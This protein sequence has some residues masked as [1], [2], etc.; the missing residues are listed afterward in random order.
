M[1]LD[2]WVYAL[3]SSKIKPTGKLTVSQQKKKH[4]VFYWRKHYSLHDWMEQ[5]YRQKGGEEEAFNCIY[6]QLEKKDIDLL[7]RLVMEGYFYET[8]QGD[9]RWAFLNDY[10]FIQKARQHLGTGS[11]LIYDSWW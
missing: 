6:V 10:E 9:D 5:L 3:P 4:E 1:G 8:E 2:A 7:E 11:K